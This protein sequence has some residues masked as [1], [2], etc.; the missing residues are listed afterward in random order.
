MLLPLDSVMGRVVSNRCVFSNVAL[1]E[2]EFVISRAHV[3]NLYS[4]SLTA[5]DKA[6]I[7]QIVQLFVRNSSRLQHA[8]VG[9]AQTGLSVRRFFGLCLAHGDACDESVL[10]AY[11][12]LFWDDVVKQVK[13][14]RELHPSSRWA[15]K[16]LGGSEGILDGDDKIIAEKLKAAGVELDLFTW[17][18][19]RQTLSLIE[20]KR[21]ECDDRAVGQLLRYYQVAWKLLSSSEYRRLNINY[22]WPILVVSRMRQPQLDA[23]PLHFQGLLDILIYST[24]A[25]GLPEFQSFRKA[26]ISARWI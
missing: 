20:I 12:F 25:Q 19:E 3:P 21:G 15:S 16:A 14:G 2:P 4:G 23:L 24:S 22:L 13:L 10:H 17:N 18:L 8:L 11:M 7:G 5:G 1:T 6:K 9:S 26:A